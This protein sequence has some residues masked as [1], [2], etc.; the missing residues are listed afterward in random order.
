M[1]LIDVN[2][3]VVLSSK[4]HWSVALVSRIKP[5]LCAVVARRTVRFDAEPT[6]AKSPLPLTLR[7]LTME[8]VAMLT[9]L[10][11]KMRAPEIL[12]EKRPAP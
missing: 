8:V 1:A 2:S 6:A 10:D 12:P 3:T 11:E 4:P 5:L 9:V 7:A